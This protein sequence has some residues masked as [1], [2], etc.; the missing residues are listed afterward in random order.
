MTPREFEVYLTQNGMPREPVQQLTRLF[1]LVRYGA[2]TAAPADEQHAVASL[3]AIV[4]A[5]GG[6]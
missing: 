5:C 4:E 2:V 3:T 6:S 1:E